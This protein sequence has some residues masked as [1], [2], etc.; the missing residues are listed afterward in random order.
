MKYLQILEKLDS[1]VFSLYDLKLRGIKVYPYQLSEWSSKGYIS[2][3]K[4]GIYIVNKERKNIPPPHIA[5]RLYQPSYLSLEWVLFNTGLIPEVVNNYTSVTNRT[6][7]RY[8]N[9]MGNFIYRHVKKDLFFG[10][11]KEFKD[12]FPYL[13]AYPEKALVDFLYLNSRN[14]DSQEDVEELRFHEWQL[15]ELDQEKIYRFAQATSLKKMD[16]ILKLIFE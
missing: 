5:F 1:P 9:K 14:L 2:K 6:G 8:N 15:E 3:L 12:G 4:N 13:V 11:Y 10:Y 16:H 7:G